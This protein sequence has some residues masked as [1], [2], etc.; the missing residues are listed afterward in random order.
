MRRSPAR[1]LLAA[2]C[3]FAASLASLADAA[4]AQQPQTGAKPPNIVLILSD[5]EDL[6][7]HPSMAKVKELIE[8][9]GT[10]FENFFVPYPLCCP[11]RAA[12]L[13]WSPH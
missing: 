5:D 1:H 4:S 13:D 11:S 12:I 3:T 9:E 8:D 10:V 2:F 6:G 7:I